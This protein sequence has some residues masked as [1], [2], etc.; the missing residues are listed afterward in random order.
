MRRLS[1]AV[2]VVGGVAFVVL[3]VV[4]VPWHW[5]P[6]QSVHAVPADAVFTPAQID[7]AEHLSWMLRISG[8][9][10][11]ALGLVV[12]CWLGFTRSGS[13]L[14]ARLPGPW[15]LMALVGCGLVMLVGSVVQVPL[16]ARAHHL[17][18]DAGLST[19]GWGGWASDQALSFGVAWVFTAIGLLAVMLLARRL[20]R[21]WPVWA[22]A[23]AAALTMLGSFVYPVVVEPL[24]NDFTSMPAG[25]M[26]TEIFALARAENV[27]IDDVLVADAS[28]RTTT[29]N[30]YV[31][32]FGST[33][34]VV[35]YDTVLSTLSRPE[36]A[37][38]VAHELGHAKHRDVLTG[39]VLGAVGSILGVGLLGLLFSSG[40]LL[41]RTG[42]DGVGDPR[43]VPL[44]LALVA[45][46]AFL[47]SPAQNTIS[48]AIE[49]RADRTALE[50][51]GD[52]AT[53]IAMQRQLALRSLADP[54]P[55]RLSQF[56]FGSHPTVLQR[57]GMAEAV[58][59]A[60]AGR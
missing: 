10:N 60:P 31:S 22:A 15:W 5:L 17:Q 21:S 27:P 53:F 32:G 38:I 6:G 54:T 29:L 46:G 3:A 58:A 9:G 48:R 20:P 30:A 49:A 55:P 57:I 36:V 40:W 45:V 18:V 56:W 1:A 11:L 14:V 8:W 47:A 44:L 25:P 51:T 13:R 26:R 42:T 35:V 43:A 37:S 12:A 24:F 19:Q 34:R 7:R 50:T 59:A 39:T 52:S 28:R 23:S 41:R 4:L 2:A 16:S 33:R